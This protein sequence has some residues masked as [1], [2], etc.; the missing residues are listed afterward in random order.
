VTARVTGAITVSTAVPET[1]G[2]LCA[3]AVIV[4]VPSDNAVAT[5]FASTEATLV[6]EL[7]HVNGSVPV[8]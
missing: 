2:L 7:L 4:A 3:V 6:F 1:A 5:P 8:L